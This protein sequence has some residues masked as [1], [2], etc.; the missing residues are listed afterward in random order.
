MTLSSCLY[1][2]HKSGDLDVA[3]PYT[4]AVYARLWGL[5]GFVASFGNRPWSDEVRVI[6]DE[7]EALD[8]I[9]GLKVA[10]Q[11]DYDAHMAFVAELQRA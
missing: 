3:V 2:H 4:D 9:R 7:A 11:W 8:L 1:I 5:N 6:T 10:A